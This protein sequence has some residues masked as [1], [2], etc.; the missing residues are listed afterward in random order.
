MKITF[1]QQT[2][3]AC[4]KQ[5]KKV[6]IDGKIIGRIVTGASRHIESKNKWKWCFVAGDRW[7]QSIPHHRVCYL[8][9]LQSRCW[10]DLESA[11]RAIRKYLPMT[12]TDSVIG[13][14]GWGDCNKP[15]Y[16][17]DSPE[18][19]KKRGKIKVDGRI[20]DDPKAGVQK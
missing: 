15:E 6:Y 17:Y 2:T 1:D 12:S 4:W 7:E 14:M 13:T 20:I 19:L 10:K 11:E 9:E 3:T 16:R 18:N 5:S 8:T